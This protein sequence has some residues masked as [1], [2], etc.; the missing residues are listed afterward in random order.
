[1]LGISSQ[2]SSLRPQQ[3]RPAYI[4]E[5]GREVFARLQVLAGQSVSICYVWMLR[6]LPR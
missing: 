6:Y 4:S 2:A 5:V 1:M 3:A